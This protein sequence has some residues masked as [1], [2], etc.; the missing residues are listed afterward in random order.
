VIQERQL[1]RLGSEQVI[2]VDIRI[3]AATNQDLDAMVADGR[4]RQ[5]LFYRLNVLKFEPLPL[6]QRP[7]DIIP[8]ALVLLR[9]HA[10]R[11][12]R[13]VI[14]LDADL[15]DFL[16][17]C[18]WP[19]NLRQLSNVMERIAIISQSEVASLS[20]VES[21]LD[22]LKPGRSPVS[23]C[24]AF[25]LAGGNLDAIRRRVVWQVV[26][27]ENNCKTQAARRLGVNRSTLNRWLKTRPGAE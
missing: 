23:A 4:F 24:A 20:G 2:P 17:R 12:R 27:E 26:A 19:G 6:R 11:Y 13:P 9:K 8:S 21:V 5:D 1:M 7:L 10:S 16:V 14:D 18:D 25:D 15:R 3:I 22:D